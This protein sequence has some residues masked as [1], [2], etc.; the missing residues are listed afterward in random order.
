MDARGFLSR[1]PSFGMVRQSIDPLAVVLPAS[2]VTHSG[3]LSIGFTI[4]FNRR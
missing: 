2:G 3:E 1:T 4:H